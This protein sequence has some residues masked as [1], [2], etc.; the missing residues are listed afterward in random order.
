MSEYH[1]NCRIFCPRC[2]RA[3]PLRISDVSYEFGHAELKSYLHEFL[4]LP[5]EALLMQLPEG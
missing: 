4:E 3:W 2:Y 5:A 1:G